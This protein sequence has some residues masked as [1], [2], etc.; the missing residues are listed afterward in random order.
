MGQFDCKIITQKQINRDIYHLVFDAP[1]LIRGSSPGQFVQIR[2]NNVID[3]LLRRPFSIHR[4]D[5]KQGRLEILYRMV[6]RGTRIMSEALPGSSMNILGPLGRGFNLKAV[7]DKALVVAGGLGC[8]PVF[9]L[10]DELLKRDKEI[11]L[12]WGSRTGDEIFAEEELTSRGVDVRLST[13]DGTKGEQGFVTAGLKTFLDG[14][15]EPD[16]VTGFVCGP[17]PMLHA[18]QTLCEGYAMKWQV[19]MEEQMACGIG[20]CQGCAVET[21]QSGIQMVCKNG[22]VFDLE[23]II[24]EE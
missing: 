24:F 17:H 20:V 6:G 9:Y 18:V 16:R 1:N 8:A 12:F 19:S 10:I 5:S 3:P 14:Q 21:R 7:G 23:D 4:I 13:E 11:T 22:P 15:S 2:V